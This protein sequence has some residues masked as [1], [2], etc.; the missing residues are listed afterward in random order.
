LREKKRRGVGKTKQNNTTL[1]A[2]VVVVLREKNK[3]GW[4]MGVLVNRGDRNSSMSSHRLGSWEGL[5]RG[6]YP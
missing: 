6:F 4:V 5:G 1:L 2:C 3:G